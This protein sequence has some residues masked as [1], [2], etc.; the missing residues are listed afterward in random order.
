[1]RW[2]RIVLWLLG[3]VFVVLA[4][5]TV[6][7]SQCPT[8]SLVSVYLN[9]GETKHTTVEGPGTYVF[10]MATAS[11]YRE[12]RYLEFLIVTPFP[13]EQYAMISGLS[14]PFHDDTALRCRTPWE[15]RAVTAIRARWA[16]LTGP[17]DH[18]IVNGDEIR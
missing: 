18:V 4:G 16:R 12:N 11:W 3:A 7:R 2:D 5:V 8:V 1:V 14:L 10:R 13:G 17:W 6:F 9:D 15:A